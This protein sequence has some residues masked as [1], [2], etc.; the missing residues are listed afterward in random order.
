M[1]I[2]RN[3]LRQIIQEELNEFRR[4]RGGAKQEEPDLSSFWPHGEDEVVEEGGMLKALGSHTP[5][6]PVSMAMT[7]STA[8]GREKLAKHLGTETLRGSRRATSTVIGDTF[9]SI[10]EMPVP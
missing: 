1:R 2:T 6:N 8:N 3:Q 4:N 5:A 9:Y 7:F 10:V